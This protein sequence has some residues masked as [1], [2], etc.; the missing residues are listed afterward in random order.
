[1]LDDPE[2]TVRRAAATAL[3][4]IGD[5]TA[6]PPLLKSL[7]DPDVRHNAIASLGEVGDPSAILRLVEIAENGGWLERPPALYALFLMPD[8][9]AQSTARRLLARQSFSSRRAVRS[10]VR[11]FKKRRGRRYHHRLFGRGGQSAGA[12]G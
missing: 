11:K 8:E 3:G 10:A 1:M 4:R 7:D 6:T 2:A 5:S 12:A 9:Y